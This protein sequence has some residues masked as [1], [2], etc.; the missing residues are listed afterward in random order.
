MVRDLSRSAAGPLWGARRRAMSDD[1]AAAHGRAGGAVL[2]RSLA[3]PAA[4]PAAAPAPGTS[5][6]CGS[7]WPWSLRPDSPAGVARWSRSG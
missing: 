1:F 4:D 3:G 7:S 5:M 2:A 6:P